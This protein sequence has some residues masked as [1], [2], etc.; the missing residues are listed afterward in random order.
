VAVGDVVDLGKEHKGVV[1][2]ISVRTIRLRDQTGALH[3]VPFSEVTSVK[4]MT[5]DYAYAVVRSLSLTAKTPTGS[6]RSC[7]KYAMS[8][9][10]TQ[11]YDRGSSI[12]STI[13][14]STASMNPRWLWS[15]GYAP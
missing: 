15:C 11:S 8:C 9:T 12:H 5:K 14:E 1:E 10:R 2:A 13:K 6:L 7:D 3:T 4:N